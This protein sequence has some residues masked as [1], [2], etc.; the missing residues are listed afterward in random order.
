M[1]GNAIK[2]YVVDVTATVASGYLIL[3]KGKNIAQ[4]WSEWTMQTLL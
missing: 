4:K 3:W 2:I 1:E